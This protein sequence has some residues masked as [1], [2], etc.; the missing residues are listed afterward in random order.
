[1]IDI[2]YDSISKNLGRTKK[3]TLSKARSFSFCQNPNS[4]RW[5][6]SE[7]SL[8]IMAVD[9][10]GIGAWGKISKS[11]KTRDEFQCRQ[12]WNYLKQKKLLSNDSYI[13]SPDPEP[14]IE[15]FRNQMTNLELY[16]IF[17]IEKD[18]K[19]LDNAGLRSTINN[20]ENDAKKFSS[21]DNLIN[22]FDFQE[23]RILYEDDILNDRHLN[24]IDIKSRSSFGKF[25]DLDLLSQKKES[26]GHERQ[27]IRIN[28]SQKS[29][30][31]EEDSQLIKLA[32]VYKRKWTKIASCLNIIPRTTSGACKRYEMLISSWI[33]QLGTF[34]DQWSKNQDNMLRF[35]NDYL[36]SDWEKISKRIEGGVFSGFQCQY[37]WHVLNYQNKIRC[38]PNESHILSEK[39]IELMSVKRSN[40]NALNAAEIFNSMTHTAQMQNLINVN[41]IKR[42][43]LQSG[44][45]K[46]T[47][48]IRIKTR[49]VKTTSNNLFNS[50]K[51][52]ADEDR[53]L[54]SSIEMLWNSEDKVFSWTEVSQYVGTRS[55]QQC[56]YRY[57]N[58]LSHNL[59]KTEW[60]PEEDTILARWI[61]SSTLFNKIS[62]NRQ[63]LADIFK[64]LYNDVSE[65]PKYRKW[66]LMSRKLNYTR[67]PLTIRVR[68]SKI[69]RAIS[70]L[71]LRGGKVQLGPKFKGS[72]IPDIL[73]EGKLKLLEYMKNLDFLNRNS[74][75]HSKYPSNENFK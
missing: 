34:D 69:V 30:Q 40:L 59:I 55:Y 4:G 14:S 67:S 48:R 75:Q 62:E 28:L 61:L 21:L 43:K 12:R 22:N 24:A 1:M 31:A 3:A 54:L 37:R 63:E 29:W 73:P 65:F 44:D 16:S 64:P 58:Y 32:E 19:K 70:E 20:L 60:T 47:K 45:K 57:T 15:N 38:P 36:G 33:D 74:P 6:M 49:K 13:A 72:G 66:S 46:F 23:R 42:R 71:N 8:L 50:G 39:H 2:D 7:D 25:N 9:L 52:R 27:S 5:K 11:V 68:C 41:H 17:E 18:Q 56:Q 53:R 26:T 51:W 10:Y 35:Y